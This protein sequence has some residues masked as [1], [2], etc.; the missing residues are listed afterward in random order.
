MPSGVAWLMYRSRHP[1]LVSE[2]KVTTFVP[3]D[4]ACWIALHG[5]LGSSAEITSAF[6]PCWAAVLM[7]ETWPSGVAVSGPTSAYLP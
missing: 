6:T 2:S 3:A 5:A 4:M 7:K 1:T